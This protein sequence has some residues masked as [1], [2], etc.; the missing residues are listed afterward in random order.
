MEETKADG[1]SKMEVDACLQPFDFSE[2]PA[3]IKV[4]YPSEER[5]MQVSPADQ[6]DAI[7]RTAAIIKASLDMTKEAERQARAAHKA[8]LRKAKAEADIKTK[9]ASKRQHAA[10][11]K[12]Q[13]LD[14]DRQRLLDQQ[15]ADLLALDQHTARVLASQ[16]A[17]AVALSDATAAADKAEQDLERF[18]QSYRGKCM[19]KGNKGKGKGAAPAAVRAESKNLSSHQSPQQ[20]TSEPES[21]PRFPVVIQADIH[22]FLAGGKQITLTEADLGYLDATI[23]WMREHD[24]WSYHKTKQ[25]GIKDKAGAF[26]GIL[27]EVLQPCGTVKNACSYLELL[28]K[29]DKPETFRER[30]KLSS[31]IDDLLAALRAAHVN[32]TME[33]DWIKVPESSKR[34]SRSTPSRHT[35]TS[36]RGFSKQRSQRRQQQQ[37]RRPTPDW[38]RDQASHTGKRPSVD[39]GSPRPNQRRHG[40]SASGDRQRSTNHGGSSR[41]GSGDDRPSSLDRQSTRSDGVSS[42]RRPRHTRSPSPAPRRR[43]SSSQ[44]SSSGE[45]RAH[46]SS[47]P[48]RRCR[49]PSPGK[50]EKRQRSTSPGYNLVSF[51]AW[52]K[53]LNNAVLPIGAFFWYKALDSFWWLGTIRE[54]TPASNSYT[55]RFLDDPGPVKI[56]LS[57]KRYDTAAEAVCGS[58]CLQEHRNSTFTR[59]LRRS[60]DE[61]GGTSN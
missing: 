31:T 29:D 45:Q 8:V 26:R 54:N 3:V 59:G 47:S 35:S 43:R 1:T 20:P 13:A 42:T 10:A 32:R 9:A 18:S 48:P 49:T 46:R 27:P 55:V 51:Q 58:W 37:H 5:W 6:H 21:T 28:T 34:A 16:K 56:T 25:Q 14:T 39:S 24:Q 52:N 30:V 40:E 11:I 33:P 44:Q 53:R 61:S 60:T 50:R 4:M 38:S 23:S 12:L 19:N 7:S 17:G 36:S 22:L 2:V 41:Q 57:P 15:K